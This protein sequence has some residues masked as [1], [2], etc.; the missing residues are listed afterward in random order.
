MNTYCA[1]QTK[2]GKYGVHTISPLGAF[3]PVGNI[4]EFN[5]F[6]EAN[7]V[8]QELSLGFYPDLRKAGHFVNMR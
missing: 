3:L 6:D 2:G 1:I 8:A 5:T 7:L 4:R